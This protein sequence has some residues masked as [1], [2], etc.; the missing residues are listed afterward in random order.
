LSFETFYEKTDHAALK[1]QS[2]N[3][4]LMTTKQ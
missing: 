4:L 2:R 1:P 3:I